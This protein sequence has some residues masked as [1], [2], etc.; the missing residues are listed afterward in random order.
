MQPRIPTLL[1]FILLILFVGVFIYLFENFS[2]ASSSAK[3]A[4]EPRNV[5]VTNVT[6]SSFSITWETADPAT[7]L[8]EVASPGAKTEVFYDDRD[9]T[10]KN[11]LGNFTTHSVTAMGQSANTSYDVK[12][13]SNGKTFADSGKPYGATTA[14]T[15]GGNPPDLEPAYGTVMTAANLP[16]EGALVFLSLD[17]SQLL[18]TLV[19]S[20]GN[21]LIPLNHIRT[22]DLNRYLASQTR[23]T[24]L[25]R[26]ALNG[27]EANAVTDTLNDAPVPV[28]NLGKTY[29]FRRIQAKIPTTPTVLGAQTET[30]ATVALIQPAE[31]AALAT[32][33]PFVQG[34]GIAG[35]VVSVV[36]GI[37]NPIAGSTT[38][39]SD[40]TWQFSPP[41]PLGEGNQ[42]VTITTTDKDGKPIAITH[43]FTIFK[44]GSQ[45][46]GIATPSATIT[47]VATPTAQPTAQ[48]I[49]RSGT[50]LPTILL[51]I[52]GVAFL[53]GGG[54]LLLTQ[55]IT[56]R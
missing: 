53:L 27:Q 11:K 9:G 29:D 56:I 39:K 30:S 48:P 36:L 15:I 7:G 22:T 51:L 41:S 45:V 26:I 44:S 5:T 49:P 17:K 20:S 31:G 25:L 52:A 43:Q 1:G 37:T 47:P 28:M 8:I 21:W 46:L 4:V 55:Q 10:N 19:G 16:A 54:S 33:F 35:K 50:A 24:E 13:L 34:I 18:S 2:R 14:P 12:L 42:S 40:G 3:S 38:V 32:S 23:I 6:D